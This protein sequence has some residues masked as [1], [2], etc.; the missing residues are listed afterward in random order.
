MYV[1]EIFLI[2]FFNGFWVFLIAKI[3]SGIGVSLS[4][5]TSQALLYDSLKKMKK[6]K[7][8]KKI[9][10]NIMTVINIS[11][12]F[13]FI[14]GAFLFSLSAK[15]PAIL[16]L[17]IV[18]VGF[19]LTFFLI[20]PYK[21]KKGLTLKN[22]F[23]HLKEGMTYFRKHKFIKYITF[24]ALPIGAVISM[25]LSLSSAYLEAI[26]IPVSL[27]GVVAFVSSMLTAY[28]SKK[29]DKLEKRLGEKKSFLLIQIGIIASVLLMSLMINHVGVLFYFFISLIAGFFGIIVNH[30]MNE[31]IETSHR[32]T[33]L[34]IKNL[35]VNFGIF[36]LFPLLGYL[37]KKYSM[38][39]SF[40]F[41][42]VF[43]LVWG[44]IIMV[45]FRN[46]WFEKR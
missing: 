3:I 5:G 4:S 28:S 31:N 21:G 10:G 40:G 19:V 26:L 14:I 33:M 30:Y 9:S 22:S 8:H 42:W 1:I 16:S 29:A 37:I 32:A 44:V 43:L 27:I 6:E 34:S 23:N 35:F 45:L 18:F 20:E 12:A 15:L 13:V 46:V 17:P 25:I 7:L 2:A 24:Y 38:G 41:L 39:I 36:V 11:M